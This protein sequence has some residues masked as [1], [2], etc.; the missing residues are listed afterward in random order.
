MRFWVSMPVTHIVKTT[1]EFMID[2]SLLPSPVRKEG[3]PTATV[4]SSW[5]SCLPNPRG[6]ISKP[7]EELP[8]SLLASGRQ[9]PMPTEVSHNCAG[10]SDGFIRALQRIFD[11]H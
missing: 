10:E 9:L 1:L 6:S 4:H 11:R 5:S 2:L 8:A 7:C 3:E